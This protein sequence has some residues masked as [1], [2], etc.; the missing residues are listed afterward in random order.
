MFAK[1]IRPA[2]VM[3]ILM[4]LIFGELYHDIVSGVGV[5][6]FK[7]KAEGS[8][9]RDKNGKIIGSSLIAVQHEEPEYFWGRMNLASNIA[10]TN[11]AFS[12]A[13]RARISALK[14]ADPENTQPI[15][16]DLITNSS[17]G[18]DPHISLAAALYQVNR[19]AS[20]RRIDKQIVHD[21]VYR[22]YQDRQFGFMGEGRVNVTT[23]NLELG[24]FNGSI[25]Q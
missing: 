16:A 24:S 11:P 4:L 1:Y 23:L 21:M 7:D 3:L 17:S 20:A 25:Q 9:V 13:V 18:M 19:V 14:K 15:P 10:L 22:H 8:L 12:D 6:A 2:L 5:V